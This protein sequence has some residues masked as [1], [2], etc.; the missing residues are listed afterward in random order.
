MDTVEFKELM[1]K[2]LLRDQLAFLEN[3]RAFDYLTGTAIGNPLDERDQYDEALLLAMIPDDELEIRL[4]LPVTDYF[5]G[6]P[7]RVYADGFAVGR[8]EMLERK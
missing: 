7:A 8:W 6:K 4:Y 3:G 5:S 2:V 1:P